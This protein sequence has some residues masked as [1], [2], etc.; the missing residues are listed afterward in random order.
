MRNRYVKRLRSCVCTSLRQVCVVG[1]LTVP[2]RLAI[3][4]CHPLVVI[5]EQGSGV[6]REEDGALPFMALALS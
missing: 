3:E 2:L 1:S 6:V 4:T 5:K